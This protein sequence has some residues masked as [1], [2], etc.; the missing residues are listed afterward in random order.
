M[1]KS[2]KKFPFVAQYRHFPHLT[3]QT[4]T[5]NDKGGTF[6]VLTGLSSLQLVT[7]ANTAMGI[8]IPPERQWNSRVAGTM[9]WPMASCHLLRSRLLSWHATADVRRVSQ[10]TWRKLCS[11]CCNHFYPNHLA[12][13]SGVTRSYTGKSGLCSAYTL[14]LE[15]DWLSWG[16]VLRS[17]AFFQYEMLWTNSSISNSGALSQTTST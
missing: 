6:W 17:Y 16:G 8:C 11:L 15:R 1:A 4:G 2:E 9:K 10:N 7:I 3:L 5:E 13:S 12:H 14:E